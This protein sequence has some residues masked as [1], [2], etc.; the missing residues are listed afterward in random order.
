VCD[1]TEP[2]R[3][4][5]RHHYDA[6]PPPMP[7]RPP[8]RPPKP[9]DEDLYKIPPDDLL[10]TS[11]RVGT[12]IPFF[13]LTNLLPF[14][15]FLFLSLFISNFL[16]KKKKKRYMRRRRVHLKL[17]LKNLKMF[18]TFKKLVCKKNIYLVKKLKTFLKV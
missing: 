13:F 17:H 16:L 1:V 14:F 12:S 2:P 6:V 9:V 11:K 7:S 3:K 15:Y 8:P 10:Y 18:C 4:P 5:G